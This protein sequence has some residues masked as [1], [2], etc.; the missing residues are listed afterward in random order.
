[1]ILNMNSE[2]VHQN[3]SYLQLSDE[4]LM[5]LIR[6]K[7]T[8]AFDELYR[9]YS[10]RLLSYFYRML[11]GDNEKAQDFLQ[12]IFLKIVEKPQRYKPTNRFA[13]WLYAVA[14]NMCKNEYRALK[15]R[16]QVHSA[17]DL[18]IFV[19]E[20]DRRH[21]NPDLKIDGDRFTRKL[22]KALENMKSTHRSTFLL[23]FQENFS[24]REI[25]EIL[26]CSEGTVK[27]RLFYTI[28]ELAGKLRDFHLPGEE[29]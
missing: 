25:G 27:S 3:N 11:G 2:P 14:S 6:L 12:N 24:I 21:S 7:E 20:P 17:E 26:G 8:G 5:E 19:A 13:T 4:E 18:D 16:K 9:R 15:V 23:R 22:L 10:Q 28:R 29:F 1:M